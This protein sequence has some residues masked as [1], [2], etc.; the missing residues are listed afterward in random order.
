MCERGVSVRVG[1]LC[2]GDGLGGMCGRI[3]TQ[4]NNSGEAIGNL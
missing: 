1:T 3:R 2:D 4:G